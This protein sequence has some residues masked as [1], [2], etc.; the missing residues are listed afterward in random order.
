MH[1]LVLFLFWKSKSLW[2]KRGKVL[3]SLFRRVAHRI[4][5]KP[6]RLLVGFFNLWFM[7]VPTRIERPP[8]WKKTVW[9]IMWLEWDFLSI[10]RLLPPWRVRCP[11][12]SEIKANRIHFCI[13]IWKKNQVWK[14]QKLDI[15]NWEVYK[16]YSMI[17]PIKNMKKLK[18]LKI[19]Y[20]W[21]SCKKMQLQLQMWGEQFLPACR[22]LA[23]WVKHPLEGRT[24]PHSNNLRYNT[25]TIC[26][27][28]VYLHICLT[29]L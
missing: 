27:P 23:T 7:D 29:L 21:Q 1:A 22:H 3:T 10:F 2:K 14:L 15:H 28:F 16:I 6:S 13:I 17:N 26:R 20:N 8:H 25:T 5:M 11:L 12:Q 9:P 18:T 4:A 24:Q 19:E